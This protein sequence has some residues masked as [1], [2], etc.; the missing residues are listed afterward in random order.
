MNN[1]VFEIQSGKSPDNLV[2]SYI[3]NNLEEALYLRVIPTI[4]NFIKTIEKAVETVFDK[5]LIKIIT[6]L[7]CYAIVL[8]LFIEYIKDIFIPKI[9]YS[10]SVTKCLIRIIPTSIISTN[11]DLE[12]WLDKINN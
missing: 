2:N 12:I 6:I 5:N 10:L 4:M 9:K 7:V 8:I 11:K 1:F 3:F